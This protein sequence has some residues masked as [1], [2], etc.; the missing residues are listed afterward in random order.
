MGVEGLM[1]KGLGIGVGVGGLTL[2][3]VR[4]RGGG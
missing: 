4:G 3:G 2:S 1:L